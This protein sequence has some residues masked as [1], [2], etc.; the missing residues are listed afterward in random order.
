MGDRGRQHH[1][2]LRGQDLQHPR[3]RPAPGRR[4]RAGARGLD[5]DQW[6]G[7]SGAGV[8]GRSRRGH[9]DAG[10]WTGKVVS[11]EAATDQNAAAVALSGSLTTLILRSSLR[12]YTRLSD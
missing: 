11:P 9:L 10:T 6:A 5:D 1:W 2:H 8:H 7:P 12:L 3:A 4:R